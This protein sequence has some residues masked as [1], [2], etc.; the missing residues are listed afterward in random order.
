MVRT[1]AAPVL[2][3]RS[4]S[5]SSSP[6]LLRSASSTWCACVHVM[7]SYFEDD[8]R[9]FKEAYDKAVVKLLQ[10]PPAGLAD[11]LVDLISNRI[12]PGVDDATY[13]KASVELCDSKLDA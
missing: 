1:R 13:V 7:P 8:V 4:K 3:Q 11:F 12:P 2:P 10:N 6:N 5:L 9:G